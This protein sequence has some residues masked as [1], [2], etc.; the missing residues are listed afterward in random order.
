MAAAGG[1]GRRVDGS[2]R[3][4]ARRGDARGGNCTRALCRRRACGM[5]RTS[6]IGDRPHWPGAQGR[7]GSGTPRRKS[8]DRRTRARGRS[9]GARVGVVRDRRSLSIAFG[10]RRA[11]ARPRASRRARPSGGR[12]SARGRAAHPV[13]AGDHLR[14]G[15]GRG[16][17]ALRRPHSRA[18]RPRP[19]RARSRAS[20]PGAS[21]GA[22]GRVRRRRR[23]DH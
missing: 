14:S 22:A 7:G 21:P 18:A 20:Y 15:V 4:R 9:G 23:G 2:R 17:Y 19:G 6:A 13:R 12:F 11:A 5:A 1:T 3:A 8:G 16:G 10:G